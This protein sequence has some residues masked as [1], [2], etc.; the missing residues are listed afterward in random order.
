MEQTKVVIKQ[1]T[2]WQLATHEDTFVWHDIGRAGS[3]RAYA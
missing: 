2:L 3:V 1:H